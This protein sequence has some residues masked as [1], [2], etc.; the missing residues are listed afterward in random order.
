[1]PTSSAKSSS[2][3]K[4]HWMFNTNVQVQITWSNPFSANNKCLTRLDGKQIKYYIC[5]QP[6]LIN[7]FSVNDSLGEGVTLKGVKLIRRNY[8]Y[9]RYRP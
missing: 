8:K 2:D 9:F 3:L 5:C 1:M 4:S 6:Q 7:G